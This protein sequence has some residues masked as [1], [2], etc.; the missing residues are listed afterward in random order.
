MEHIF[1]KQWIYVG[2]RGQLAR[3]GDYFT[4]QIGDGRS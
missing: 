2:R 3:A 1:R 4:A